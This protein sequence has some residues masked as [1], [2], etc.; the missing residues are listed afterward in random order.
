LERIG[1]NLEQGVIFLRPAEAYELGQHA[2]LLDFFRLMLPLHVSKRV[3]PVEDDL[4]HSPRMPR[5]IFDGD[6]TALAGRQ[7]RELPEAGGIDDGFEIADPC[8]ERE[9]WCVA[10]RQPAPALIVT[11]RFEFAG[12]NV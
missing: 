7:N 6:G 9:V 4:A 1:P 5:R 3:G 10:A 8:F 2:R 12:K 11:Q